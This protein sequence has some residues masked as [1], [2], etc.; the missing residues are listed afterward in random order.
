[1]NTD[2]DIH[3]QIND[4]IAMRPPAWEKGGVSPNPQGRPRHSKAETERLTKAHAQAVNR[5][6]KAVEADDLTASIFMMQQGWS[7]FR[8]VKM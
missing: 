5:V 1:M 4:D 2:T 8:G 6:V 7:S 3:Q